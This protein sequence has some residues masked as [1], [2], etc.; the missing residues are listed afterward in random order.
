MVCA[1]RWK[2][3][4][5]HREAKQL[6]GLENA[7][8]VYHALFAITSLAPFSFWIR[9][10]REAHETAQTLYQVKHGILSEYLREQ[11]KSPTLK[12]DAA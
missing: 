12:M 7:N 5:F 2:I 3:E 11:L 10:M 8:V 1:W 6:T 9:L 4:Q